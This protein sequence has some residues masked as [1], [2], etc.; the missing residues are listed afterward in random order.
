M[1]IDKTSKIKADML[2]KWRWRASFFYRIFSMGIGLRLLIN[3]P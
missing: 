2:A 1:N 3:A